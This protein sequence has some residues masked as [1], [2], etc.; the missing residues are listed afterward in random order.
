MVHRWV[1]QEPIALNTEGIDD[2][3][4]SGLDEGMEDVGSSN[5]KGKEPLGKAVKSEI[6]LPIPIAI[7]GKGLGIGV[8][9]KCG[10][11]FPEE[12]L[13]LLVSWHKD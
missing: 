5:G 1:C 11:F 3:T 2:E 7:G 10:K 6:P 4:F 8:D 9:G 12:R 13:L